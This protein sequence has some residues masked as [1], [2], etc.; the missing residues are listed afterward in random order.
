MKPLCGGF[1]IFTKIPEFETDPFLTPSWY[2]D[3]E[4]RAP[5]AGK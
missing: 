1:I 2:H 5:V 4:T 3:Q